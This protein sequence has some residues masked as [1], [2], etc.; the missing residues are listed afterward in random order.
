[1][2]WLIWSESALRDVQRLYRFLLAKDLAAAKRAVKAI[3]HGLRVLGQQPGVGRPVDDAPE[4]F[5]EWIID[6]GDGGFIVRYRFD[7]EV[8]LL[9]AARHQK[10]IGD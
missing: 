6:F 3:H 9:L 8:V 2:P 5:R 10:E 4:E 1:M 7:G